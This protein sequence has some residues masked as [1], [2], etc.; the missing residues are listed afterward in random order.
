MASEWPSGIDHSCYYARLPSCRVIEPS[1]LILRI[2]KS[3]H[4]LLP[5]SLTHSYSL[6]MTFQASQE[7]LGFGGIAQGFSQQ[8]F[9]GLQFISSCYQT[10]Y[11][12][13][14]ISFEKR[15]ACNHA[16]PQFKSLSLTLCL[17][18]AASLQSHWF[19]WCQ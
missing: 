4:S 11:Y 8:H 15:E 13:R 3:I 17:I 6:P 9:P 5:Q 2:S 7:T 12:H 16:T 10:T 14:Y 18:F 1:F 19:H